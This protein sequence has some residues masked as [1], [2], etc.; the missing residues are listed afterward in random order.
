MTL[1][2]KQDPNVHLVTITSEEEQK[3]IE[4]LMLYGERDVYYTGGLVDE[5]GNVYTI[6]DENTD[7]SHW[8]T[9]CPEN[10]GKEDK[11][12]I[13]VIFR[14][15]G[16]EPKSDPDYG[17]WFDLNEDEYNLFDFADFNVEGATRG[18]II[19]WDTPIGNTE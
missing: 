4:E 1:A 12:D 7:Y 11:D 17:Y 9:D 2:T 10:Y 18:I 15:S 8:Y 13:I 5:D 16:N 14:G 6:N 19:E 3:I